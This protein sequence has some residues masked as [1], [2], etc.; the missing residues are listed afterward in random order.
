MLERL[1]SEY[2]SEEDTGIKDEIL[3]D[4]LDE[5]DDDNIYE[6]ITELEK[7]ASEEIDLAAL[8]NELTKRQYFQVKDLVQ[9]A[10]ATFQKEKALILLGEAMARMS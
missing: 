10:Q 1:L 9:Q 6:I 2:F 7:Y 5:V 3:E 8:L 4:I